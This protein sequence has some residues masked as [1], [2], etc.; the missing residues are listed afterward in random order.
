MFICTCHLFSRCVNLK[1]VT[2]EAAL[3]HVILATSVIQ[4]A[5]SRQ[6]SATK[7]L[8]VSAR[9]SPPRKGFFH[10][11]NSIQPRK[12][13]THEKLQNNFT[14]A[15]GRFGCPVCHGRSGGSHLCRPV[16]FVKVRG[17]DDYERRRGMQPQAV[18]VNKNDWKEAR[19]HEKEHNKQE[20]KYWKQQE[21]HHGKHHGHDD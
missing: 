2:T 9:C 18:Y 7:H 20:K 14:T 15:A 3:D 1:P 16:Y 12:K 11:S 21:K 6:G 4:R 8:I 5:S 17:D 10:S 19:K 13:E